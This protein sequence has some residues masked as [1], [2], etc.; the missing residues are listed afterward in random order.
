MNMIGAFIFGVITCVLFKK[1]NNI[2]VNM[3]L[4]FME[5]I[6]LILFSMPLG[7]E[8]I[9]TTPSSSELNAM[10]IIGIILFVP[11][12]IALIRYLKTNIKVIKSYEKAII[13]EV[14]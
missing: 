10:F 6:P 14:I 9:S 3:A 5:N 13:S 12:I 1:Y 8:E 4:H 2:L 7:S 11:S